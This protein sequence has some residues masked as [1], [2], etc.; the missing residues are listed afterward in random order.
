MPAK[1]YKA[2]T[3]GFRIELHN[4][5]PNVGCVDVCVC[6]YVKH[7]SFNDTDMDNKISIFNYNRTNSKAHVFFV[8]LYVISNQQSIVCFGSVCIF[9]S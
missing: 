6:P 2:C 4:A 5:C 1:A 8:E 9:N 7:C 3:D